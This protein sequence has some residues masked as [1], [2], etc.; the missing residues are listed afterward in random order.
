M[1]CQS[2]L[3]KQLY[4]FKQS[5]LKNIK[6]FYLL[7][8]FFFY[9]MEDRYLRAKVNFI[10]QISS[11]GIQ[12]HFQLEFEGTHIE[13]IN[14][15]E[16]EDIANNNIERDENKEWSRVCKN[17]TYTRTGVTKVFHLGAR[18]TPSPFEGQLAFSYITIKSQD[19]TMPRILQNE[20]EYPASPKDFNT[21]SS[22]DIPKLSK[23]PFHF[24]DSYYI[25]TPNLNL[26]RLVIRKVVLLFPNMINISSVTYIFQQLSKGG[27]NSH[28]EFSIDDKSTK[29]KVHQDQ[30]SSIENIENDIDSLVVLILK[31]DTIVPNEILKRKY[32]DFSYCMTGSSQPY[33]FNNIIPP[34]TGKT[35][36][37]RFKKLRCDE[38]TREFLEVEYSPNIEITTLKKKEKEFEPAINNLNDSTFISI[39]N[40]NLIRV[41]IRKFYI[42]KP[43]KP[44][45]YRDMNNFNIENHKVPELEF[46]QYK[47]KKEL[48]LKDFVKLLTKGFGFI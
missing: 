43:I 5:N 38:N 27:I 33:S 4:L 16:K 29:I 24:P 21:K 30:D 46:H 41:A 22:I 19:E 47:R 13:N 8:L 34:F 40:F 23:D 36:I 44:K 48:V 1:L 25:E 45:S 15:Y 20:I 10:Y 28:F 32:K 42:R 11:G 6:L 35:K 12:S 3:S 37:N 2:T 39:P 7:Q 18:D 26:I 14:V 17:T 31:Y 9:Q